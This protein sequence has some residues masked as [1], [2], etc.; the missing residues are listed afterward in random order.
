MRG[1][2]LC[3]WKIFGLELHIQR[4]LGPYLSLG[5]PPGDVRQREL[6]GSDGA[7]STCMDRLT[8][9]TRVS[10][11]LSSQ[12]ELRNT[13]KLLEGGQGASIPTMGLRE[14][15]WGSESLGPFF[16]QSRY[17]C[18]CEITPFSQDG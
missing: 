1:T 9:V 12:V 16:L 8:G 15:P 10:R 14:G 17:Q 18:K 3:F 2:T 6:G 13:E 11:T 5:W 4:H 7:V